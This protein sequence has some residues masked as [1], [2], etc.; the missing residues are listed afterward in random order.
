MTVPVGGGAGAGGPV[1]VAVS[2]IGPPSPADGVASVN[3][4]PITWVT[5]DA[6]LGD[7]HGLVADGW[8]ASPL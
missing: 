6:S 1:T 5:T 3:M 8:L 2:E 7:P 4:S